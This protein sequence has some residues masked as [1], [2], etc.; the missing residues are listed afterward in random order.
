MLG[1]LGIQEDL[2]DALRLSQTSW[3]HDGT[4]V[5]EDYLP[6]PALGISRWVLDRRLA[7][8]FTALG[9]RLQTG[10]R[11]SPG[12]FQ[13]GTVSAAGRVAAGNPRRWIGLKVH[14][15]GVRLEHDLEIHLGRRGY[16]GLSRIESGAVNFCGLFRPD[17]KLEGKAEGLLEAACRA[18]G[19]GVALARLQTGKVVEGSFCAVSAMD[20]GPFSRFPEGFNLGDNWGLIP[21][22]TGNGMSLAFESAA[23]ALEPLVE[24]SEGRLGWDAAKGI[25]QDG[26]ENGLRG[27]VLRAR[28]LHLLLLAPGGQFFLAALAHRQLLPFHWLYSLTH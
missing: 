17:R 1:R 4:C 16:A 6:R 25:Y 24:W 19:L 7:E 12:G 23:A 28:W 22:F 15:S 14:L 26:L 27:R 20:Y 8:R 18:S 9:G 5:L 21:P 10:R 2:A 13:P 3:Y 11:E